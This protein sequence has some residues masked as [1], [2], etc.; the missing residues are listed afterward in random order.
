MAIILF[1]DF[2]SEGPYVGQME[3]V[4]E[5]IAPN[6]KVINLLSNAPQ[7]DPL[8]SAYLLAAL[9]KN[10][11]VGSIF[12]AVVDPGVGG[13]RLALVL[14]ADGHYFVGPDN[15]LFNTVAVQSSVVNWHEI[16]WRPIVCS[17]SFHGRDL[18]APIA[19]RLSV[20]KA[21]EAIQPM[22]K[23]LADW[24]GDVDKIIYCDHY[25]NAMTGHRYTEH[26]SGRVISIKGIQIQQ[27]VT[28]CSVPEN[29]LF[30]YPNS[31]GLIEIAA[32]KANAQKML[33]LIPG[34]CFSFL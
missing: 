27:A 17:S 22:T 19:A 18:F 8:L 6:T 12:L 25:G 26:D 7:G 29:N 15:G 9:R 10:F 24:A 11:P 33:N 14:E 5:Q 16:I 3:S 1:T 13:D 21:D 4:I 2:G 31:S 32:N 28:F 30:W 34:E 23:Q 20:K